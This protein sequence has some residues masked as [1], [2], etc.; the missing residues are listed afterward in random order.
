V[1]GISAASGEDLGPRPIHDG[2]MSGHSR[3]W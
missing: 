3:I 1:P 2:H